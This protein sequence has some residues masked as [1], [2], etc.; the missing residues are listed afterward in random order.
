MYKYRLQNIT[1]YQLLS[2]FQEANMKSIVA[3]VVLSVA[4]LALHV[5][6]DPVPEPGTLGGGFGGLGYGGGGF[7]GFG[8][9]FGG[10]SFGGGFGGKSLEVDWR[11]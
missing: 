7:G 11:T 4:F 2:Y 3:L 6:A 8:G 10:R 5:S 1:C 9:G